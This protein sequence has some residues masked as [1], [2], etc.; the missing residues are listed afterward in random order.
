M[1]LDMEEKS[2]FSRGESSKEKVFSRDFRSAGEKNC[3]VIRVAIK[4]T[5]Q[6]IMKSAIPRIVKTWLKTGRG[7]DKVLKI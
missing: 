3:L 2:A 5:E 1:T 4:T 7:E 6:I